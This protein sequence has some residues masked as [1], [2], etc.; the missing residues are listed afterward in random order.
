MIGT[1]K[2]LRKVINACRHSTK[3]GNPYGVWGP[4]VNPQPSAPNSVAALYVLFI[5]DLIEKFKGQYYYFCCY[6]NLETRQNLQMP[7]LMPLTLVIG[8]N[9]KSRGS[10]S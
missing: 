2:V 5:C 8:G 4:A 1:L 9:T 7:V 3:I 10:L 6:G